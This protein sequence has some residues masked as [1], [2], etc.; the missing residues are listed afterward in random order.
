MGITPG[1]SQQAQQ[2]L[3]SAAL[4]QISQDK[5][6]DAEIARKDAANEA[7][8]ARKD[9]GAKLKMS[10]DHSSGMQ[11]QMITSNENMQSQRL[12]DA[13]KGRD[14]V[15]LQQEKQNQWQGDQN[16]QQQEMALVLQQADNERRRRMME[17]AGQVYTNSGYNNMG[18]QQGGTINYAPQR[19]Q[20]QAGAP[21]GRFQYNPGGAPGLHFTP[22]QWSEHKKINDG[23]RLELGKKQDIEYQ[24]LMDMGAEFKDR[25]Q[26]V[27][28]YIGS[29]VSNQVALQEERNTIRALQAS[30]YADVYHP[31]GQLGRLIFEVDPENRP[32]MADWTRA[33]NKFAGFNIMGGH[34]DLVPGTSTGTFAYHDIWEDD[35]ALIEAIEVDREKAYAAAHSMAR[36]YGLSDKEFE[37]GYKLF[38]E[39]YQNEM[40]QPMLSIGE[41]NAD[42]A[43]TGDQFNSFMA[44]DIAERMGLGQNVDMDKLEGMRQA[45]ST[46]QGNPNLL[47]QGGYGNEAVMAYKPTSKTNMQINITK[48]MS[49]NLRSQGYKEQADVLDKMTPILIEHLHSGMMGD[50]KARKEA[51]DKLVAIL[52]ESKGTGYT[53]LMGM[54]DKFLEMGKKGSI[55]AEVYSQSTRDALVASGVREEDIEK[56]QDGM[57][58]SRIA[59][60]QLGGLA[61]DL[62]SAGKGGP[63]DPIILQ[64]QLQSA[65]GN[66]NPYTGGTTVINGVP[67]RDLDPE[68]MGNMKAMVDQSQWGK[69][70]T[71]EVRD[72]HLR[73]MFESAQ[74]AGLE[75]ESAEAEA[76]KLEWETA[77]D[78][79]DLYFDETIVNTRDTQ[80]ALGQQQYTDRFDAFMAAEETADQ[81]MY[82][83]GLD[84][85]TRRGKPKPKSKKKP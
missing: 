66:T 48:A 5:L 45:F 41:T 8:I 16:A 73:A 10:L 25:Q 15:A 24:M 17:Y 13:Q 26:A 38:Q 57:K 78:E 74:T 71:P 19:Y 9:A 46:A 14:A 3:A 37:K 69:N 31:G 63:K 62:L 27:N 21:S 59:M 85:I 30:G 32:G 18:S 28:Q 79:S 51:T 83:Q 1:I 2:A 60:A 67:Y 55:D 20:S 11:Q 35:K 64:G 42:R 50:E 76:A 77:R 58:T 6:Q 47:G 39:K 61:N 81:A 72:I 33:L 49:N 22:E 44:M 68:W 29:L 56:M 84:I 4:G 82:N 80:R 70:M 36:G 65:L 12:A 53:A 52:S 34:V 54:M 7:E 23:Q 40:G 43:E 75:K